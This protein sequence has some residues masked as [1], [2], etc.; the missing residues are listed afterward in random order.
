MT[1]AVLYCRVSTDLQEKEQ[2]IGSQIEALREYARGKGYEVIYEYLDDGYSGA[3]LER[4]GLDSMRDALRV[5]G[6]DVVLFHS[7][8]RLARKAIYQGLVLEEMENGGVRPEFLNYPIDDTP[9]SKML[10]GMQGLFAEYE[11]AKIMER[12]RRGKLHRV[13]E[14][15]LVG[16]HAP[17]GYTWIRRSENQRARLEA[18]EPQATTVRW[19]Y[20]VLQE[21]KIST[22]ALAKRLTALGV[23]TPKGAMRWQ[24]TAVYRI[25]TNSAY[26]GS[27]LYRPSSESI[28]SIAV[29]SIVKGDS[30]DAVQKQL[31]ENSKYSRRNNKSN[32]Y[33][34]RGLINCSRCGGSYTGYVQ[35]GSRGYR[36]N[37]A[38]W[39]SS[40]TGRRCAPGAIAAG[41]I[42]EV[43]WQAVC[44]ALSQPHILA[45]E[46][47][48]RLNESGLPTDIDFQKKQVVIA[49]KR[50]KAREDRA[51]DA[52]INEAMGL[53]RYK[54]EMQKLRVEG[55]ELDR[56]EGDIEQREILDKTSRNAL[57]HL[58]QF[59]REISG[60]LD[61]M[62]FEERQQ[63]LRLVVERIT[64]EDGKI[65]IGAV[66][67]NG[68]NDVKL[69]N[70][71][72]E[73][74]EPCERRE[75]PAHVLRQCSG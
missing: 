75:S 50:V 3:T 55:E 26:K 7:P 2:T 63:L 22:W 53:E 69:H 4:P 57:D 21:E 35:H 66:I 14:G 47:R 42:E 46:Y 25:L 74:V 6:F 27:Y 32:H 72:G 60:G 54:S 67:P 9:E 41:P 19:M 68:Y 18:R 5:G 30:W 52:Y 48:S 59:C 65:R 16:G 44:E 33:L 28:V 13:R 29:P 45:Q 20:Q 62:T 56:I 15:A 38:N 70:A 11:R 49:R 1:K 58:D 64:I 43:V 24:P 39:A 12:T 31:E 40:S 36:C 8:D 51:T 73:L 71:R 17:Y 37:R 23:P 10:L 61:A 34:L